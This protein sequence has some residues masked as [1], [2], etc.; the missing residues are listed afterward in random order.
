MSTIEFLTRT[1][2]TCTPIRQEFILLSDVFGVSALI[3]ALNN[4]P[5]GNATESTVLGPF[6]T[7]D[8]PDG[9]SPNL[10]ASPP[11]SVYPRLTSSPTTHTVPLGESIA[12]EG[13]GEYMYVEGRVLTLSGEPIPG[14]VIETWETDEKGEQHLMCFF[15][16]CLTTCV[17]PPTPPLSRLLR[18]SVLG[19]L[20]TRLPW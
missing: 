9:S 16:F 4:P 1:G 19:P 10:H 18:Y 12:S 17:P 7:E 15:L 6:F 3:D 8:A 13:K 14:A 20:R 11:N 2:Q 5:V